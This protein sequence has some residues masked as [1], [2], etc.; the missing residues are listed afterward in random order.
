MK[1]AANSFTAYI[2][3]A[4]AGISFLSGLSILF[5]GEHYV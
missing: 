3:A 4:M 1:N 2:L 5:G